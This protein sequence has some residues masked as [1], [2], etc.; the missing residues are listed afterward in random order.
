MWLPFSDLTGAQ[1]LE[2]LGFGLC[3]CANVSARVHT[4][5]AAIAVTTLFV[6][7]LAQTSKFVRLRRQQHEDPPK[8]SYRMEL[9][10][11]L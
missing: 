3:S 4:E 6:R 8:G 1:I 10:Q 2:R 7:F 11:L 9:T 5:G